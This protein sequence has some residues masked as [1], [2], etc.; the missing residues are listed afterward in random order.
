[1]K[2]FVIP[3]LTAALATFGFSILFYVHPRHLLLATLGGTLTTAVYLLVGHFMEGEMI[4]SLIA[5]AVGAGFSE[6]CART[7]KV[8]VPVYMLPCVIPLVPGSGLY[9]TM[10]NL[11]TGD[12]SNA[13]STG[14]VTLQV[15]LG[16]AGGIMAVSI[17]SIF[18]RPRKR[19]GRV[20]DAQANGEGIH[21]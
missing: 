1:M 4:P 6:I 9:A 10:F 15:A 19:S 13:F 2:E 21:K 17:V 20:P 5:A 8:P 16:I 14:L 18:F 3:L 7:T 12:Y 11:V